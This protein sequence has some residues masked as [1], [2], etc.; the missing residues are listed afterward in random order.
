MAP[1]PD[2][3]LKEAPAFYT[4]SLDLFGPF[5]IRDT[6]KKRTRMKVWGTIFTCTVTRALHL[7]LTENYGTDAI[8]ETIRKFMSLRG[9]P[10]EF[11]S[12]EG[13]QLIAASK[14][15]A[16]LVEGWNW[17]SIHEYTANRKIK[18]KLVPAE[19]QHQ[20]GVSESLIKSVKRS[21]KHKVTNGNVLTFSNLQMIFY[22]IAG[23]LNSLPI[24]IK[25]GSDPDIP[26]PLTPNH[27]LI[28]R[29]TTEVPQGPF[30]TTDKRKKAP[31][32][33][34]FLQTIV[35][36]WWEYWYQCVLPTLVP[37]YK[38]LQRHRNVAVGDVCLIRYRS[39]LRS[40]YR[41]GRVVEVRKGCDGLVRTVALQYKLPNENFPYC[42]STDS[43]YCCDCS[44]RGTRESTE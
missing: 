18:W 39:E 17:K 11:Q 15:I 44:H 35:S 4:C 5:E 29:E 41:L 1:L 8:L 6:V 31:K 23:I 28:G 9:A 42:G 12:D 20:N 36:E 3:R 34:R 13:S 2:S 32:L 24:G 26:L 37:N 27:L 40:T 19:G 14:E 10:S 38:W 25:S 43:W 22:E 16:Q 33:F 21:I 30:A 7:D